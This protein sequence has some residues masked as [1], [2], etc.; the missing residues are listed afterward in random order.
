MAFKAIENQQVKTLHPFWDMID[1]NW[2]SAHAVKNVL[3]VVGKG[4]DWFSGYKFKFF[5]SAYSQFQQHF[6]I[7]SVN[8]CCF[9]SMLLRV[10][11]IKV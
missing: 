11:D 10:Y 7:K 3:E 8:L 6:I 1:R 9:V 5:C 4:W 2:Y